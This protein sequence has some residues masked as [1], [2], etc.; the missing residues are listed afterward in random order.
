MSANA[1]YVA[2]LALRREAGKSLFIEDALNRLLK[3]S[4]LEGKN[5]ALCRNITL[6]VARHWRT[7]QWLAYRKVIC[8]SEPNLPETVLIILMTGIF[9]LL[10]LDKV[11]SHAAVFETVEL[12][13]VFDCEKYKRLVNAILRSYTRE[14][15]LTKQ[16]LLDLRQSDPAL[17]CAFPDWLY[18]LLCGQFG[19]QKSLELMDF[20]N[21]TPKAIYL[22]TNTL[23]C[24]RED[25]LKRLEMEIGSVSAANYDFLPHQ[26]FISVPNSVAP[27]HI[28]CFQEGLFYVQD[29]AACMSVHMMDPQPG[30]R[31]LDACAAPG[32]KSTYMAQLM[33]NRGHIVAEDV[34]NRIQLIK[35]NAKRLGCSIIEVADAKCGSSGEDSARKEAPYD[36]ILLDVPCSNTGVLRR[37]VEARYRITDGEINRLLEVQSALLNMADRRLKVGGVIAYSTCSIVSDENE[38][39]VRSFLSRHS[40]YEFKGERTLLPSA[41]H[42]GAYTAILVKKE[43]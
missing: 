41:E 2:V 13:R 1:R 9:Q 32:G 31:I 20:A 11:P 36:R 38:M 18:N 17:A 43:A 26:S 33:N 23:K 34:E 3:T 7:L 37:R 42:D 14:Y 40:N 24:G 22:R 35:N 21:M 29:P 28:P 10:F 15:N 5:H 30:E 8:D 19:K 6:G 4:N 27:A 16:I 12:C 39:Q 25:L